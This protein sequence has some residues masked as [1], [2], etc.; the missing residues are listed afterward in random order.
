MAASAA[1]ATDNS[2]SVSRVGE[3]VGTDQA[4]LFSEIEDGI[5]VRFGKHLEISRDSVAEIAN[6]G[7]IIGRQSIA[8]VDP[9]GSVAAA[10]AMYQVIRQISPLPI[11]HVIVTHLHPDHSLGLLAFLDE[12]KALWPTGFYSSDSDFAE[13]EKPLILGHP[14]LWQALLQNAGFF[15]DNFTDIQVDKELRQVLENLPIQSPIQSV[16]NNQT[17]DLGDRLLSINL[18]NNSHSDADVT[19]FDNKTLT[20]WAG[21][22]MVN[23]RLPAL[24]GSLIAWLD[25]FESLA[26][27]LEKH[28]SVTV[29][30][31]HGRIGMWPAIADQQLIYLKRLRDFTRKALQE[32]QS[33]S[34]FV[35][36]EWPWQRSHWELFDAQH[37]RN[38]NRAYTELEWE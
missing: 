13:S 28:E 16:K 24:D 32:G 1:T 7:F 22:F 10:Q 36:T 23:Q 37:Q 30:P 4:H 21:D 31:G 14:S 6:T 18:R 8:I 15:K 20:L 33:L 38:A 11:S 3:A 25:E 2:G 29:I 19:V 17:I 34:S 9:G 5:Y 35:N 27:E 26:S 12:T